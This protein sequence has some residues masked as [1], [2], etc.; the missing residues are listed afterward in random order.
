MTKKAKW[1]SQ[2]EQRIRQRQNI[3]KFLADDAKRILLLNEPVGFGKTQVLI[4]FCRQ[5]FGSSHF[6]TQTNKKARELERDLE[7]ELEKMQ[8]DINMIRLFGDE[9]LAEESMECAPQTGQ[10][11][12]LV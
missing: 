2:Q 6:L 4:D 7:R 3:E 11:I 10:L 8:V 1:I 12:S 9:E 5:N